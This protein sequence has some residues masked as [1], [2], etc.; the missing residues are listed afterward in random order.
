[1]GGFKCKC[2]LLEICGDAELCIR[3]Y[4]ALAVACSA[5][6]TESGT[7][8]KLRPRRE[9]GKEVRCKVC[10]DKRYVLRDYVP[11]ERRRQ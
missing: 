2:C 9:N 8:G 11:G 3:C 6:M 4:D 10:G 1:M 7:H 5:C